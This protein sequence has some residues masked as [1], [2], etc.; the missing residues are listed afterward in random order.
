MICINI[1]Q[2]EN[3]TLRSICHLNRPL[4][5][6]EFRLM[7]SHSFQLFILLY[8]RCS[9]KEA[10]LV[11][12]PDLAQF[13]RRKRFCSLSPFEN[14]IYTV[15]H[16][17]RVKRILFNLDLAPVDKKVQLQIRVSTFLFYRLLKKKGFVV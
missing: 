6:P 8:F 4:F 2:L 16:K 5:T 13:I 12:F 10:Y 11:Q 14:G 17:A 15:T 9:V 7:L 1:L 3:K